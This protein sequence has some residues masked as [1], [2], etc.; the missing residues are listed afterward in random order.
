[1]K[2]ETE[3]T[4]NIGLYYVCYHLARIDWNVMPSAR[5]A[6]EIDPIA[7]KKTGTESIGV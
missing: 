4:G 7:Y 6:H 5:N 1:M 3:V 2:V